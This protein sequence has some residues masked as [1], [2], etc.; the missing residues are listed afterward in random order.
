MTHDGRLLARAREA[1]EDERR[2]SEERT[3]SIIGS[4]R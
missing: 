1:L 4:P 3:L 2:G